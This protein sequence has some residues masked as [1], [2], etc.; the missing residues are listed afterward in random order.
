MFLNGGGVNSPDATAGQNL[1]TTAAPNYSVAQSKKNMTNIRL[2]VAI[3]GDL[4][5]PE[6]F[7]DIV[8]ISPTSYWY[9]GDLIPGYEKKITRKETCWEYSFGNIETLDFE[10]ISNLFMNCFRP[11]EEKVSQYINKN[12]L[13]L[14]VY[15]VIEIIDDEKPAIFFNKDFMDLIVKMNGC[16]DMDLYY[17]TD[18]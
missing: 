8:K 5:I 16:I 10:D 14:K 17:I 12:N 6:E 11:K 7:S 9:K 4:L 3:F 1:S 13:E 15:I 2:I 18:C